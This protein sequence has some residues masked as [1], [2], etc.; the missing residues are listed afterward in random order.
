M[1]CP[2]CGTSQRTFVRP[3][4]WHCDHVR[5]SPQW[6]AQPGYVGGPGLTN[7]AAGPGLIWDPGGWRGG[8]SDPCDTEYDV[9]DDD[10]TDAERLP[11]SNTLAALAEVDAALPVVRGSALPLRPDLIDPDPFWAL[12]LLPWWG[13]G[14]VVLGIALNDIGAGALIAGLLC[15]AVLGAWL[16]RAGVL[17]RRY[18]EAE[19][20]HRDALEAA[21]ERDLERARMLASLVLPPERR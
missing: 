9:R 2:N 17:R 6:Y 18:T 14:A 13:G 10:L 5:V 20:Q 11:Y 4:R 12:G 3:G 16:L 19:R 15:L 1:P 8:G 7:P 21:R